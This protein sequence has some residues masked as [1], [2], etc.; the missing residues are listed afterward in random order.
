MALD[1]E[2]LGQVLENL[3]AAVDDDTGVSQR[4]RT[5]AYYTP[6]PIVDYMVDE[7]LAVYLTERLRREE[8][9]RNVGGG[10]RA[11]ARPTGLDRRAP[12]LTARKLNG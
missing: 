5:G 11:S 10:R 6:R 7:S 4:K 12:R 3:L 9:G 2:L 8:T 1:P